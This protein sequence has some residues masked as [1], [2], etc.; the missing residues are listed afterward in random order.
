MNA[1]FNY[2]DYRFKELGRFDYKRKCYAFHQAVKQHVL[3]WSISSTGK[4]EKLGV[5]T[6]RPWDIDAEP[7]G[8]K[9]LQPF[10]SGDE[11]VP[12]IHRL[13]CLRPFF[14]ECLKRMQ[15]NAAS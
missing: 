14:G 4:E 15:G 1:G 13:L 9:P 8:V 12:T 11:L 6:L 7:A 5:D 3:P 2:R 10:E